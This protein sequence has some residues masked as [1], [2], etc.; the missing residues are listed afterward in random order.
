LVQVTDE[1]VAQNASGTPRGDSPRLGRRAFVLGAA[2]AGVLALAGG[3]AFRL[4]GREATRDGSAVLALSLPD[5][6]GRTQ[7][8][9]Q[10]RGKVLIVNFWAT[11][12]APCR[13]EMPEFVA[14]QARDGD[15]GVQFVGIAVD[16]VDKVRSFAREIGLNYPALIGGYGAIELS[17]TLGNNLSALPFT[18][19]L[20][21][22]GRVAHTQL[23]PLKQAKLDRLLADL[24]PAG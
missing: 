13:E 16:D 3:I 8:L 7:P 18:V 4:V 23:G 15:K 12:C 5:L 10:W 1:R 19:V 2:A 21:R 9:A 6:D 24:V 17:K 20:D 22:A 14:A 11:W